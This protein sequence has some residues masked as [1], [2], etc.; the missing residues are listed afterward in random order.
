MGATPIRIDGPPKRHL[1]LLGHAV[2]RRFRSHL[3]EAR[4]ESLRRVEAAND[5]A[6][7]VARQPALLLDLDFQLIP[8][9]ERMFAYRADG[10]VLPALLADGRDRH[11]PRPARVAV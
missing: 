10:R 6:V 3:V 5:G 2:Q 1:R 9:H 11:R 7:A 4:V 8:T